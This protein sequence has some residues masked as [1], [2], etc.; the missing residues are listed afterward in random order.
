MPVKKNLDMGGR[1]FDA[2]QKKPAQD[3]SG[4]QLSKGPK[5][6]KA[7]CPNSSALKILKKKVT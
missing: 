5:P 2:L 7:C 6:R 3:C 4:A 1:R